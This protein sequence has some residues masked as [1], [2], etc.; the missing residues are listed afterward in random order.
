MPFHKGVDGWR[1]ILLQQPREWDAKWLSRTVTQ[2]DLDLQFPQTD[3]PYCIFDCNQ[4]QLALIC[5][6]Q[7]VYT[8]A[9]RRSMRWLFDLY[10]HPTEQRPKHHL[11]QAEW[12]PSRKTMHLYL[13]HSVRWSALCCEI[14][15]K[16][17]FW[18][19][20]ALN[21]NVGGMLEYQVKNQRRSYTSI[22][23]YL[24]AL[25]F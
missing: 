1:N 19:L 22:C 4:R 20:V 12:I 11:L 5:A 7:L 2:M 17:P 6:F 13:G 14:D 21:G 24:L 9:R 16:Y 15:C 18:C 23:S 3:G 25:L 10:L 8:Y